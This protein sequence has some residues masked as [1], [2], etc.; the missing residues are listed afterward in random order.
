MWMSWSE[1][2]TVRWILQEQRALLSIEKCNPILKRDRTIVPW[3][4][5]EN[6]LFSSVYYIHCRHIDD[7]DS[8]HIQDVSAVDEDRPSKAYHEQKRRAER[9]SG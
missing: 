1:F 8:Q 4:T 7:H 6:Q 9:S 5:C 3:S 2:G